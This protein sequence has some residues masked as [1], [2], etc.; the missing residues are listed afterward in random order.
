VRIAARWSWLRVA[1]AAASTS[2]GLG[3][4][5]ELE[6]VESLELGALVWDPVVGSRD[7][8]SSTVWHDRSVW[9]FG[10]SILTQEGSAGT[11]WRNNTAT[12]TEDFDAADGIHPFEEALAE[13]D[14]GV[15]PE[16]LPMTADEIAYE[17]EYDG[18]NCGEDC[19][20]IAMWPGSPVYDPEND[21]LVVFYLKLV[22]RPGA[23][24]IDVIGSSVALWSD[25]DAF[26]ERPLVREGDEPTLLFGQHGPEL[27]AAALYRNGWIYAFSCATPRGGKKCI[28]G[29][30]RPDDVA[31][32][33]AW[34]FRTSAGHWSPRWEN[35]ETLFRGSEIMSVHYNAHVGRWLATYARPLTND[36]VMRTAPSLPGPW[37]DELV[38]H[39]ARDVLDDGLTSYGALAHPE[40]AGDEGRLEYVTYY[41][42]A[43]G[44][45]RLVELELE[46][47]PR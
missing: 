42:P 24:N 20:G 16:F 9:V 2:V 28:L 37:S 13:T 45:L 26:P 8:G 44:G 1:V 41:E 23:L 27:A 5:A 3:C 4:R 12:F 34:R 10:D 15:P 32:R 31:V 7:G 18:P 46:L 30:V 25:P 14:G 21:R 36:I 6:V 11:T 19:S 29:R 17:A 38:V 33:E 39:H 35:A 40:F 43:S 22:Q 47:E